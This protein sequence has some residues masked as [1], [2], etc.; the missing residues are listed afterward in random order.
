MNYKRDIDE[1]ES[2]GENVDEDNEDGVPM[3]EDDVEDTVDDEE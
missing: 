1:D 2:C 3:I